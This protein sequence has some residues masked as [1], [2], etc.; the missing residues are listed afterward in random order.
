MGELKARFKAIRKP[1]V[2]SS[3]SGNQYFADAISETFHH[4]QFVVVRRPIEECQASLSELGFPD[5]GSLAH[6][7]HLLE[8]VIKNHSP[9]VLDFK[10]LNEAET[11]VELC[12]YLE[13]PFD[14]DRFDL[15]SPLN[16]QPVH[17]FMMNQ[18]NPD[19][20]NA[21]ND[22]MRST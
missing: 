3:D 20:I 6:S 4:P 22:L 18:V 19:T 21:M 2:G 17:H 5:D 16:I 10:D 1:V 8:E 14:K 13:L 11:L 9:L 15:L 12:D 7:Q